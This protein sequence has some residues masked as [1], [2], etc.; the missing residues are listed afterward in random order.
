LD[1]PEERS[2]AAGRAPLLRVRV[3]VV[4]TVLLVAAIIIDLLFP[5]SIKLA[6]LFNLP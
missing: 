6:E 1:Q 3:S 2:T 5:L 4:V